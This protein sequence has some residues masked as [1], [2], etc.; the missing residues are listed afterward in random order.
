MQWH[1]KYKEEREFS[2]V[3]LERAMSVIYDAI[4]EDPLSWIGSNRRNYNKRILMAQGMIYYWEEKEEYEKCISL[5]KVC[6]LIILI[7]ERKLNL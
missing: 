6:K 2:E 3:E 5:T 7:K 1:L 4:I